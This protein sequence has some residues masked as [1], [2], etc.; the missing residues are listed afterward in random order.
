MLANLKVN[1]LIDPNT[2]Y[3]ITDINRRLINKETLM[4]LFPKVSNNSP[5]IK[6]RELIGKGKSGSIYKC[7]YENIGKIPFNNKKK[8][9][10]YIAIKI[11]KPDMEIK[12]R[13]AY[14]DRTI[15]N[16]KKYISEF[17][18]R[19]QFIYNFII[20]TNYFGIKSNILE[21]Y[22]IEYFYTGEI[23]SLFIFTEY[24][25]YYDTLYHYIKS[26]TLSSHH[27]RNILLQGIYI[28]IILSQFS[29]YHNDTNASNFMI[30][31]QPTIKT[32]EYKIPLINKSEV[33]KLNTCYNIKIIDFD[34]STRF[35]QRDVNYIKD[36]TNYDK[37]PIYDLLNF[38]LSINKLVD[39]TARVEIFEDIIFTK[40]L[41]ILGSFGF[42]NNIKTFYRSKLIINNKT[43]NLQKKKAISTWPKIVH[44]QKNVYALYQKR[45]GI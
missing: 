15:I 10:D 37:L 34:L 44:G 18:K 27:I 8:L 14:N 23:T 3:H 6:K 24:L 30:K 38:I 12:Q 42:G 36:T 19:K 40:E 20:K 7:H 5:I 11:I 13:Y 16:I 17:F 43:N 35:L 21:I 28:I 39:V 32:K 25:Q 22:N 33:I 4:N 45:T 29:F 1:L 26:N 9:D 31:C 2:Y 41:S